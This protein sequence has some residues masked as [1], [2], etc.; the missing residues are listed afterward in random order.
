[1]DLKGAGRVP[2]ALR[3]RQ[4]VVRELAERYRGADKNEKGRIL[5][6]TEE[7]LG[8][9]RCYA[10]RA[11]R[12]ACWPGREKKPRRRRGPGR[13]PVYDGAV[14][15]ALRK[16]WAVMSFATGKRLAPFMAEIVPVLERHGELS[17][18]PR[19][20]GSCSR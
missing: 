8:Y 2:L 4:V 11:L 1:M 6:Q 9:N 3:E 14:V 18:P 5:D 12:R 13:K 15:A 7:L 19:C 16:V 17:V 10:A 20:A